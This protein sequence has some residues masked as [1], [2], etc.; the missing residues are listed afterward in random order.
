MGS[1]PNLIEILSHKFETIESSNILP[2]PSVKPDSKRKTITGLK[3]VVR[4]KA[5][6]VMQQMAK[7]QCLVEKKPLALKSNG[8]KGKK[9]VK[10]TFDF[11]NSQTIVPETP[12]KKF[13]QL[14]RQN[15]SDATSFTPTKSIHHIPASLPR[16]SLVD[17]ASPV[18]YNST[19]LENT[20]TKGRAKSPQ[21]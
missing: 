14:N 17:F 2:S 5:L 15:D 9:I 1:L 18:R 16:I 6:T 19:I 21:D 13:Y 12:F 20:P 11:P 4:R 10:P 3:K 8:Q 7:R